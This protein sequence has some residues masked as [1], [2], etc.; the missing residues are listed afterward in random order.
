MKDLSIHISDRSHLNISLNV[1][2]CGNRS[3]EVEQFCRPDYYSL[4]N[5]K[6]GRGSIT[7]AKANH[8]IKAGQCFV[9][10]PNE[11]A[12]ITSEHGKSLNVTWVSFSGYL[13]D[14]YLGRAKISPFEPVA[15]DTPERELENLFDRLLQVAVR[16]ANRYCPIMAQLYSIF[17]FL[18]DHTQQNTQV[19]M[20][21]P[22]MYLMK[23]LD[24]IDIYYQDNIT[25]EDVA[26]GV[27]LNRK[28]LYTIF[29][30]LTG[31]ST[32]D[33][34]IYYR[35]RRASDLLESTTLP[36]ETIAV[37]VGYRDQF[38][39]SKEFKKNVGYSPSEYRRVVA[40]DPD[41]GYLSPIDM[42]REQYPT[43][44]SDAPRRYLGNPD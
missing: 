22:E 5:V 41:K 28:S 23:A 11:E 4:F 3:I 27:G 32:K 33:Y 19:E 12:A 29:K 35:M 34:L 13:V 42:V 25:V 1:Y 6:E 36:I 15:G 9:I 20:P 8:K 37:S 40:Q 24:F 16:P 17:A 18:L 38:H 10:Y 14:A 44:G 26:D 2:N 7:Q 21:P 31:F 43:P 39:F 30:Q